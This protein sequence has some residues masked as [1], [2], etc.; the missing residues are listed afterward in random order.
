MYHSP[1]AL[2]SLA[3]SVSVTKAQCSDSQDDQ[4]KQKQSKGS[5]EV[6]GGGLGT[7]GAWGR[8]GN[9]AD[10]LPSTFAGRAGLAHPSPQ[11]SMPALCDPLATQP[12]GGA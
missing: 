3:F 12:P 11:L 6:R 8:A 2:Q 1:K 10:L 7:R 5:P 9:E 4:C